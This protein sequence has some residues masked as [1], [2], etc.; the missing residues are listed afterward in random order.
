MDRTKTEAPTFQKKKQKLLKF[1]LVDL[2]CALLG[3]P[4]ISARNPGHLSSS[5][6]KAAPDL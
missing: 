1:N 4:S 6:M 5:H 3:G 2:W